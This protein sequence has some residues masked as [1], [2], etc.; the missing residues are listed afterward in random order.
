MDSLGGWLLQEQPPTG[1]QTYP[2]YSFPPFLPSAVY[3]HSE[4]RAGERVGGGMA[5]TAT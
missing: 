1:T 2:P 3:L 5:I 4:Y